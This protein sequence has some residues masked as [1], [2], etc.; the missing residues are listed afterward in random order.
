[1][2]GWM[3]GWMDGDR[4]LLT[5]ASE[6]EALLAL[7]LEAEVLD[8]LD[9]LRCADGHV[10]ELDAVADLDGRRVL[11]GLLVPQVFHQGEELR[12]RKAPLSF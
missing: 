10:I 11:R 3:D 7:E 9:V 6:Q 1:M 2:D 4:V 12:L 5:V 8:Q